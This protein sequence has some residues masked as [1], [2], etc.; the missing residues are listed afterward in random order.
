LYGGQVPSV[1][2]MISPPYCSMSFIHLN[3]Y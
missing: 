2:S 1:G 3:M